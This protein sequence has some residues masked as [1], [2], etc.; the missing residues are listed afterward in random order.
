VDNTHDIL[1]HNAAAAFQYI[2]EKRQTI[3]MMADEEG[4]R[5]MRL[6]LFREAMRN[7]RQKTNLQLR[8]G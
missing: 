8:A 7:E 1:E 5:L 2:L 4:D 3:W 6:P